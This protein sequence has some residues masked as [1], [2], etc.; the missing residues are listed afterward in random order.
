MSRAPRWREAGA[1][2]Y[3]DVSTEPDGRRLLRVELR[4]LLVTRR[5]GA[6]Q[7]SS[8]GGAII[9]LDRRRGLGHTRITM[10]D[11]SLSALL[12]GAKLAVLRHTY[13]GRAIRGKTTIARLTKTQAVAADGTRFKL[14]DGCE[15]GGK[16]W[17]EPWTARHD[18]ELRLERAQSTLSGLAHELERFARL[19]LAADKVEAAEALA[20]AIRAYLPPPTEAEAVA[21][22]LAA[23]ADGAASLAGAR[24]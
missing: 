16:T 9:P 13:R 12:P 24:E 1:R 4:R 20:S 10:N 6:P 14:D 11:R 17:A 5:P 2:W 19:P 22:S 18:A 15:V 8:A 21:S 23:V 3:R 7:G